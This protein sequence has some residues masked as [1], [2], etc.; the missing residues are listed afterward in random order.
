[1]SFLFGILMLVLLV[2]YVRYHDMKADYTYLAA[3]HCYVCIS[4]LECGIDAD[5]ILPK[6]NLLENEKVTGFYFM[7]PKELLIREMRGFEAD[8]QD[9]KLEIQSFHPVQKFSSKYRI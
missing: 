7:T 5:K 1:M 8:Y 2:L 6:Y 4:C 9:G 3:R